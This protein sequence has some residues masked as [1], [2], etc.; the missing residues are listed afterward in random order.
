MAADMRSKINSR[1]HARTLA[2]THTHTQ[3]Q[4][5][6]FQIPTTNTAALDT[7]TRRGLVSTGD[8]NLSKQRNTP[9][10]QVYV[11]RRHGPPDLWQVC[12]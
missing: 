5:Q 12:M 9:K 10:R 3:C 6:P 2:H 11:R 8:N 7:E 4:L 1:A